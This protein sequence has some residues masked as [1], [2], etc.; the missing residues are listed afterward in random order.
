MSS[1]KHTV[2]FR[3][4]EGT[5]DHKYILAWLDICVHF[6]DYAQKIKLSEVLCQEPGTI[7]T[8]EELFLLLKIKNENTIKVFNKRYKKFK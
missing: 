4:S 3:L 1:T 2:E 8:L 5:L 7:K 6:V